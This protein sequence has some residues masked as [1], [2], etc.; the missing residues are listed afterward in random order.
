[1]FRYQKEQNINMNKTLYIFPDHHTVKA[2]ELQDKYV[3]N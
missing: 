1:M 2:S 3:N